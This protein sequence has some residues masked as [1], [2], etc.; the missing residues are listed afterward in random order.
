MDQYLEYIST[1]Q[2]E[3]AFKDYGR[4]KL[5]GGTFF[6]LTIVGRSFNNCEVRIQREPRRYTD[7]C[8]CK[9]VMLKDKCPLGL[10]LEFNQN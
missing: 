5:N 9:F 7:R 10:I 8:E 1:E 4:H 2:Q 6:A 3:N